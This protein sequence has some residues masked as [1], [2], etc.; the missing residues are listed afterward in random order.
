MRAK[1]LIFGQPPGRVPIRRIL[2]AEHYE[3][4]EAETGEEGLKKLEIEK[5]NVILLDATA[6]LDD[7]N[8]VRGLREMVPEGVVVMAAYDSMNSAMGAIRNGFREGMKLSSE[9]AKE[10]GVERES[11]LKYRIREGCVYLVKEKK[12]DRGAD[13]FLDL[14]NSGYKGMIVS[15]TTPDEIKEFCKIE[16]PILWL[17]EDVSDER[18]VYPELR[19]LEKTITDYATKDRVVLLDRLDYLIVRASFKE[20]LGFIQRLRELFY[21]GKGVLIISMDPDTLGPQEY[22]L[23]EKETSEVKLRV[24]P[25]MPLDLW[26]IL[27]FVHQQNIQGKKPSQK[28][29]VEKFGVT[30]TTTRKR[31]K[32][33]CDMGLMMYSKNGRYKIWELTESGTALCG[34]H[35]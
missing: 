23:L 8:L 32:R 7:T 22:S 30:R 3:V 20:V 25:D 14:L 35:A 11:N 13:V 2:E 5:P 31:I 24:E 6:R 4:V 10:V 17:S 18:A 21:L 16:V 15:R 1:I 33:L 28:V 34:A 29:I 9:A 26:G 27:E 19:S 12:L